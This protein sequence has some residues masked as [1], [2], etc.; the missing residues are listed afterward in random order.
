MLFDYTG[1]SFYIRPGATD[2]RGGAQ[3]LAQLILSKMDLDL[4]SK[5]VFLFSGK[6]R[7]SIKILVWDGNGFWLH[8]KKLYK[9]TFAWPKSEEEARILVSEDDVIGMLSGQDRWR[10]LGDA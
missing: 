6:S 3:R 5:S 8:T 10:R 9:G 1:Y 4:Y 7:S 2:M